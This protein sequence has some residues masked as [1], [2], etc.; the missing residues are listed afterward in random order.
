MPPSGNGLEPMHDATPGPW[1][2]I[3]QHAS[4]LGQSAVCSQVLR[5]VFGATK[6]KY[7]GDFHRTQVSPAG[8]SASDE[9]D[10]GN[11]SGGSSGSS[12]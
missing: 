7:Q 6:V 9:Q 3:S 8:H 12:G 11:A 2:A 10:A 1:S 5:Q 4:P